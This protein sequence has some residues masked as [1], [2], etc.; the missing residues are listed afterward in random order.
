MRDGEDVIDA[1]LSERLARGAT[2]HEAARL[3]REFASPAVPALVSGSIRRTVFILA[4]PV[5]GEQALNTL[6]GLVDTFLSGR[7]SVDATAAVG[8]ASYVGWLMAMLFMLVGTGTTAL[9]A[10][11]IGAGEPRSANEVANQSFTLASINGLIGAAAIYALA[12]A[13]AVWQNMQGEAYDIVVTYLRIDA[14]GNAFTSMTLVSA[15]ALRGVGDTRTPMKIMGLVNV[16][17]MFVSAGLVWGWGPLPQLGVNGIVLG[18]VIARISGAALMVSTLARGRSGL[19]LHV[20]E[21]IPRWT[22][23]RRI[24]WIGIPAAGEGAIMWT[25]QFLFLLII[26][27]LAEGDIGR[28][29]YAAHFVG[30]RVESLTYLPATAWAAAAA[31]MVGQA[32]GA[33]RPERAKRV[34]HEAVLQCASLAVLSSALFL[35]FAPQILRLMHDDPLVQQVGVPALRMVAFFQPCMAFSIVYFGAMRG[36]GA[37]RFP[38]LATALGIILVRLP[39]GYLCGIVLQWGLIGAWIGMV[40]DMAVRAGLATV[41]YG[42]GQ[43]V[44]VRV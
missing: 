42:R 35:L 31:T 3:T 1:T 13:F 41:R 16:V 23:I 27:R 44:H 43:W 37:T 22:M 26:S 24:L 25:G 19:R 20:R 28:A 10:R 32:L 5:L 6:V 21:L 14:I 29:Y 2:A 4:L 9:V 18:T 30:V 40:S 34:G 7:I 11:A 33:Q 39:L 36:A 17:N 8:L 12:P 15:A 38:L